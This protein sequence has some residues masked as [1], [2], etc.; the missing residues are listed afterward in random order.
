MPT[1]RLT[2]DEFG[3]AKF[4]PE[5]DFVYLARV[6]RQGASISEVLC[7]L[8]LLSGLTLRFHRLAEPLWFDEAV[9]VKTAAT[10]LADIPRQIS[11]EDSNPPLFPL[12][13]KVWMALAGGTDTSI[14]AFCAI[15]GTLLV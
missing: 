13:L 5:P 4:C 15:I 11:E 14:H 1:G 9:T 7:V 6:K 3:L 10:P 12:I 8:A 2:R